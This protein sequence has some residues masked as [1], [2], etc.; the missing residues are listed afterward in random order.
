LAIISRVLFNSAAAHPRVDQVWLA[1]HMWLGDS[2]QVGAQ[3]YCPRMAP[4]LSASSMQFRAAKSAMNESQYPI[5]RHISMVLLECCWQSASHLGRCVKPPTL[6]ATLETPNVPM[7]NV[8]L[9]I[10]P[11]SFR[12]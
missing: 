4:N 5:L 1:L 7:L 3:G 12:P 11:L 10:S 8:H 6:A 9:V 2:V